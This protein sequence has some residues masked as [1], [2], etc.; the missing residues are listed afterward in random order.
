M[1]VKFSFIYR[2]GVFF[3]PF[4]LRGGGETNWSPFHKGSI[5]RCVFSKV[6]KKISWSSW[7]ASSQI[8]KKEKI[9]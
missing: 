9:L 2:G 1:Y 7:E 3:F 8:K 5:V 4:F 6:E